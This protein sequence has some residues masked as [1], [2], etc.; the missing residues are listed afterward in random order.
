MHRRHF[1]LA[2]LIPL[3]IS[4]PPFVRMVAQSRDPSHTRRNRAGKP[5]HV[6]S[7]V[8]ISGNIEQV[9]A[10]YGKPDEVR[11]VAV[12]R[13]PE[14]SGERNYIWNRGSTITSVTTG[15]Y[16]DAAGKEVE[17]ETNEIEVMGSSTEGEI[18]KTGAGLSLG[19]SRKK[20]Y[21]MYG[22][23]FHESQIYKSPL[24]GDHVPVLAVEWENGTRLCIAFDE[25]DRINFIA[26]MASVD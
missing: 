13:A 7:G 3:L 18:G 4:G 8:D 6:L 1:I 21:Q 20:A 24:R 2:G 23:L 14:G 10:K 12:P 22:V 16:I 15:H 25:R 11:N 17:S 9:I 19:D 5:E 26:L